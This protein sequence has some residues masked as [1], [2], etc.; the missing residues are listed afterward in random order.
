MLTL[1]RI[2]K[3][4]LLFAVLLELPKIV[5]EAKNGNYRQIPRSFTNVISYALFGALASSIGAY[6]LG[7][8]G[9]VLGLGFGFWLGSRISKLLNASY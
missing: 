3:L 7:S 1:N 8:A 4:G 9:S 2:T 6:T 5:D